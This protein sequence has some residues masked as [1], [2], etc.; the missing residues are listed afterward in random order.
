M[1]PELSEAI[2]RNDMLAFKRLVQMDPKILEQKS[3]VSMNTSLHM[4]ARLGHAE[5]VA[6]IVKLRPDLVAEENNDGETP[7]HEACRQG[8]SKV[9]QLLLENY[10]MAASKVNHKN[11]SAFLLACREGQGDAVRIMLQQTWLMEQE[12]DELVLTPLHAALLGGHKGTE[13]MVV[14]S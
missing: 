6:E 9:L 10:P 14:L 13:Y 11:Q 4:A 3:D 12:E 7:I 2:E 8:N 1:D 5:L